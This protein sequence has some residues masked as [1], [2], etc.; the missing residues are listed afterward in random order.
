MIE[1]DIVIVV[2]AII[3]FFFAA[4]V[5]WRQQLSLNYWQ[6]VHVM[7]VRYIKELEENLDSIING[8]GKMAQEGLRALQKPMRGCKK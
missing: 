8:H 3:L 7:D 4:F 1:V 5:I 6:N 2:I